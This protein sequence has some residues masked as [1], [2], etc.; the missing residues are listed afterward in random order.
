MAGLGV[1]GG[2]G[3]PAEPRTA[4]RESGSGAGEGWG[5]AAGCGAAENGRGRGGSGAGGAGRRGGSL[6]SPNPLHSERC[7]RGRSG[8]AAP[9]CSMEGNRTPPRYG[10]LESTRWPPASTAPG[11]LQTF[12]RVAPVL[13][14]SA[15]L[16]PP[17]PTLRRV[18]EPSGASRSGVGSGGSAAGGAPEPPAG[19]EGRGGQG[20]GKE[21][22]ERSVWRGGG[23]A[24][25]NEVVEGGW[26]PPPG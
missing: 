19:W 20:G 26:S 13:P 2:R 1:R 4:P 12:P 5:A 21:K 7:G 6:G 11:E 16:P 3:Q 24:G 10:S 8:A 14:L 17:P 25:R 9:L 22:T 18:E 23:I 15:P